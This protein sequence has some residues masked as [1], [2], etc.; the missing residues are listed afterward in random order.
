MSNRS[1]FARFGRCAILVLLN[2][3]VYFVR[4]LEKAASS[5]GAIFH[6]AALALKGIE[7]D[8]RKQKRFLKKII[9]L[10]IFFAVIVIIVS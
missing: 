10:S 6:A 4:L 9:F 1:F 5:L 8:R 3:M 7:E 2:I